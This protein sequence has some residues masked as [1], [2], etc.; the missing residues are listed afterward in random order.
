MADNSVILIELEVDGKKVQVDLAKLKDQAKKAGDDIEK[1]AQSG[2]TKFGNNIIESFKG[3][4]AE[5]YAMR[6][7]IVGFTA[8]FAAVTGAVGGFL[9]AM[10]SIGH[11]AD[12]VAAVNNQFDFLVQKIGGTGAALKQ[13][14]EDINKGFYDTEDILQATNKAIINTSLDA[15]Q[16][17]QNFEASK[18]IAIAF[19]TDAVEA[20]QA[21]NQAIASG[22]TRILRQVGLFVDAQ[23]ASDKYAKSIGTS[24]KYLTDAQKQTAL[25]AEVQNK[26]AENF[27][28]VD[29]NAKRT[30]DA[31]KIYETAVKDFGE[32]AAVG[33]N[34]IFGPLAQSLLQGFTDALTG[35]NRAMIS[36]WGTNAEKAAVAQERLTEKIEKTN[37]SIQS[38][39][40]TIETT[41]NTNFSGYY[42][43]LLDDMKRKVGQ[44]D[45]VEEARYRR[46]IGRA[47][48]EK[49][50]ADAKK[51]RTQEEIDIANRKA[52]ADA[53][54]LNQTMQMENAYYD[55][56]IQKSRS[57]QEAQQFY[58]LEVKNYQVAQKLELEQLERDHADNKIATEE[59]YQRRRAAIID[60][61][62]MKMKQLEEKSSQSAQQLQKTWQTGVVSGMT[63]SFA[64]L[65]GALAKGENGFAAF[66]KAAISAIGSIAINI[67]AM[68]VTMGLGFQSV[69]VLFPAWAAAGAGAVV[70]GL[71]LITLGGAL[72]AMGGGSGES[73]ATGGGGGGGGFG[74]GAGAASTEQPVTESS[75]PK[76]EVVVNVQGNVFNGQEQARVIA[77]NLQEYFD[78][79]NGFLV[80]S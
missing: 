49:R 61:G 57:A 79:N 2:L 73:A 23:S 53:A 66:S 54:Y 36:V 1:G 38:M 8:P 10:K 37:A 45:E 19:G 67:G 9:V 46:Q 7:A 47:D 30:S 65:G 12:E 14:L 24:A 72:M 34:K 74:G 39:Q 27:S 62:A 71:A 59:E 4:K 28:H 70:Q 78:T 44:L 11:T 56:K 41:N 68:L 40:K 48:M 31:F 43:D 75:K 69:G 16:L 26:V 25:F 29:L 6:G 60:N 20:Y 18:R 55:F 13:S 32:N 77:D 15:K 42:S 17:T 5:I 63:S 76:T 50:F 64:A 80:R 52:A 35:V 21:I 22:N 33:L 58:D 51:Q 3:A